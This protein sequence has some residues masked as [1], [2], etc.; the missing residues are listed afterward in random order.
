MMTRG[1]ILTILYAKI[2]KE[3]WYSYLGHDM[4]LRSKAV[5]ET[6]FCVTYPN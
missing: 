1:Y 3:A 4:P 6:R 5:D 2:M